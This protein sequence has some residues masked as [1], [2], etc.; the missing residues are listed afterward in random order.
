MV[1]TL[2]S[3][4]SLNE[5]EL[6][7]PIKTLAK[8]QHHPKW[9]KDQLAVA[10]EEVKNRAPKRQ[11]AKKYGIP[12]GTIND[13][14]LGRRQLQDKP[15]TALSEVEEAEIV[16]FLKEMSIGGFGKTKNEQV[17]ENPMGTEHAVRQMLSAVQEETPRNSFPKALTIR[18]TKGFRVKEGHIGWFSNFSQV[19]KDIDA[20]ILLE[21]DRIYNCDESG[22]SL[23]ALSGWVLTYVMCH[24]KSGHKLI[25][26]SQ[27]ALL[28]CPINSQ[29]IYLITSGNSSE[30]TAR[31]FFAQN[32]ENK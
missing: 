26:Q 5:D 16:N 17:K 15:K 14:L 20:S 12:W 4:S 27:S 30:T 25:F 31:T 23:S 10:F 13:K 32:E 2:F 9:T 28:D 19:V 18:K 8:N 6:Q 29:N 7:L 21:P 1:K 3:T 24:D 22:F 11:T